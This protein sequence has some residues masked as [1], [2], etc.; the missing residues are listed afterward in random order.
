MPQDPAVLYFLGFNMT[1]L[2]ISWWRHS[3]SDTS[4]W[5][6]TSDLGLKTEIE[7]GSIY[8]IHFPRTYLTTI[9]LFCVFSL[10]SALSWGLISKVFSD[11]ESSRDDFKICLPDIQRSNPHQQNSNGIV[12]QHQQLSTELASDTDKSRCSTCI[13]ELLWAFLRLDWDMTPS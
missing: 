4:C 6:I 2:K 13:S 3:H 1:C 9:S 7:S 5:A 8:W 10:A 12:A 11:V